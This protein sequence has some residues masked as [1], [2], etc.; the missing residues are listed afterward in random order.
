MSRYIHLFLII[1]S[2]FSGAT[3][4]LTASTLPQQADGFAPRFSLLTCSPGEEIYSYFGHTAIRMIRPETNRDIVFNYGVFSFNAPN[5]ILRFALGETDYQLAVTDYHRFAAEYDYYNRGITEQVLSLSPSEAHKLAELLEENY[6]P[7]NRVYRYNFFYDNCA[8]RPRG[9]IEK[10][11]EGKIVYHFPD[12]LSQSY[13]DIIHIYTQGHDWGQFGIDLCLGSQIDT[14]ITQRQ[15]TFVPDYLLWAFRDAEIIA[16]DGSRRALVSAEHILLPARTDT[17][18]QGFCLSPLSCTLLLFMVVVLFTIYGLRRK[19]S[20]WGVDMVL[21]AA[22][23]IA[24]CVL[25]FLVF[26]SQHP[27]V[28]PNYLLFVFHPLHLLLLPFF[29]YKEKNRQRSI[30]HVANSVTLTFFILFM[31]VLPQRI[32]WAVVP[33]ALCLLVRSVS[34]LILTYRERA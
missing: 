27:G 5:F 24:G 4:P 11:I 32:E 7:G 3:I 25:A 14:P 29:L 10:C 20:L 30:Y 8:T 26:L 6:L 33:L 2:F 31:A 34:N 28:S 12:S 23:G 9:I 1:F 18:S 19:K 21:F 16:P 15:K 22:A 17:Q 13:R